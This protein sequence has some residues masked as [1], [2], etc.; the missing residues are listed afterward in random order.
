MKIFISDIIRI[1][2][3]PE[4]KVLPANL[5]FYLVLSLVPILS[6]VLFLASILPIPYDLLTNYFDKFIPND[7]SDF[8]VMVV[9]TS[10][11]NDGMQLFNVAALIISSSGMYSII[12]VSNAIYNIKSSNIIKDRIKS[13]VMLFLILIL[14]TILVV[15][16]LLGNNILLFCKEF[17][18]T[19]ISDNLLL[20]FNILK[21]PVGMLIIFST[22]KLIYTISP[23]EKMSSKT[24]TMGAMFT[25]VIWIIASLIFGSYLTSFAKYDIIYGSLSSIIILM[26]WFYILAYIFV[27]GMALNYYYSNME[28]KIIKRDNNKK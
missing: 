7:I 14:M 3:Q 23:S 10:N 17:F 20:I 18:P 5:A 19:F 22:I 4:M 24:T 21:W 1:I 25:T 9:S 2:K 12:N 27:M 16:L 15:V 11:Y 8:I 26:I 13:F 6:L 28:N